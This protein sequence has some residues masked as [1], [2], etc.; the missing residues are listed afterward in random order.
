MSMPGAGQALGASI[1]DACLT[2]RMM[3][4]AWAAM[5]YQSLWVQSVLGLSAIKAGLVLLPCAPAAFVVSAAIGRFLHTA[6]P[7][8]LAGTGLLV[9]A[10]GAGAQAVLRASSSCW[11]SSGPGRP[12]RPRKPGRRPEAVR[13]ARRSRYATGD[14]LARQRASRAG[15]A[16]W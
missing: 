16:Q 3:G 2:V 12:P 4:A 6:S 9:I 11:R 7:R 5:T 14:R 15:V 13:K 1:D 10:V 8:L